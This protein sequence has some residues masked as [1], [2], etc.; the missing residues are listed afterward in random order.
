MKKHKNLM[1]QGT[2]SSVGKSLITT[3]L[4][5][6]IHKRGYRVC[7]FKS[8]NMALNSYITENGL[9]M[10]RA[11]VV[12]AEACGIKPEVYMNPILLKP[13]SSKKSQVILN[14]RVVENMG[15]IEYSGYKEGL[16][17]EI[18]KSYDYIKK[19]YD[20]SIIEGAG[21]PVEINL[22]K[23]DIVNMGMAHMADAPVILVADIDR[24]GVFASVVGTMTLF[25]PEERARVK[26]IIINKFRG[27]VKILE[28]GLR[29]LEEI[30]GVPVLGVVPYTKLNIEDED[31]VTDKFKRQTIDKDIKISVIKLKHMSNFTDLDAFSLYK[32][33]SIKYIDRAEDLGNEDM[34]VIPGSKSTIDDL[35]ELKEIGIAEK[36]VKLSKSGTI[37]FGICGG[38]QML[39]G[40]IED[41]DKL[42]G[43]VSEISGLGL[44]DLTTTMQKSKNTLQY[45][46]KVLIDSG[47]FEGLYGKPIKGYEIHQGI[48]N[49]KEEG[50]FLDGEKYINGVIKN[51][52]IGCYI[53]G[54]FDN[55]EFTRG[56]LNNI[57]SQ[58]GLDGIDATISFEEFKEKEYD[59]L[60][61]VVEESVDMKKLYKIIGIS[62]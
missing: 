15:A 30:I 21:S 40:K 8:Q 58:K 6:L 53:H 55:T 34:I 50:I 3:A 47:L 41:P 13:T 10:G 27:D 22:K 11:Q 42:E 39:G 19:N 12:Q 57:R 20:I 38:Y 7:P 2:A 24:G 32:D 1:V 4:C 18:L 29:Q 26:G 9:E 25:T 35:K 48:T 56:F 31:G 54:I 52:I 51:N 17:K 14:G 36:I 28:P 33:V 59:K 16:K 60:A 49:G 45:H 5:R 44:L 46:G 37:V 62:Y 61:K 23:G 43:N